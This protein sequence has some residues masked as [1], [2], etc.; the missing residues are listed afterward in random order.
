MKSIHKCRSL[1]KNATEGP[2]IL[3]SKSKQVQSHVGY[4]ETLSLI[5]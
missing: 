1:K 5:K 3:H 4:F 2:A